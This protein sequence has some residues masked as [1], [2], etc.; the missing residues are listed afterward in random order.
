MLPFLLFLAAVLISPQEIQT[1]LHGHDGAFVIVD[2][3]TGE[4]VRSDAAAC[5][6]KMAPCSTFKI[7]NTAIGLELGEVVAPDDPF[8]KWDG[9]KRSIEPWNHDQ[10]LRSAFQ[11]SCMPAYQALARRIGAA[12]MQT[13]IDKLGYGDRNTSAGIDAFWLPDSGR[14]PLL[15]SPDEQAALLR[16]LV[17]GDVPFSAKTQATLKDIMLVKKTEQGTLYGKTGSGQDE[18]TGR[19]WGWYVGYMQTVSGKTYAFACLLK[20]KNVMGKDARAIV[21][22]ILARLLQNE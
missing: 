1:A 12:R 11:V 13:W 7:W 22:T 15:I 17:N 6:E 4:G 14:Q 8:W 5:A 10:T 2:C 20:G 19:D 21:E 3:A 18:K 9:K 16:R